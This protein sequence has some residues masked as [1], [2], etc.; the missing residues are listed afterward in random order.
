[1]SG[2][3]NGAALDRLSIAGFLSYDNAASDANW[4]VREGYGSLIAANTIA[5]PLV[6]QRVSI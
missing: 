6:A 3:L 4:R 5:L 1:M 2:Y